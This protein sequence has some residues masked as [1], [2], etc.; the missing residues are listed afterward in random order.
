MTAV[1]LCFVFFTHSYVWIVSIE[2]RFST[3]LFFFY[4]GSTITE[5]E[6]VYK[7]FYVS[8]LHAII[9]GQ[10]PLQCVFVL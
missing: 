8:S 9:H 1:I 5:T 7:C 2:I 10:V 4:F 3:F 6:C